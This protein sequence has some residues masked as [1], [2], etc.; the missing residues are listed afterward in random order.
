[1][2]NFKKDDFDSEFV[3]WVSTYG[4][5]TVQRIFALFNFSLDYREIKEILTQKDSIYYH[6]LRLPFINIL[7]NIIINQAESYREYLQ[8]IFIDYLLSGAANETNAPVQGESIRENLEE[9]RKQFMSLGDEFDIE[10]F[11]HNSFIAESQRA[12]IGLAKS[13]FRNI[14]QINEKDKLELMSLVD[15][16]EAR[17]RKLTQKFQYFRQQFKNIIVL[18]TEMLETLPNYNIDEKQISTYKE[19][20]DF[21]TKIG[22]VL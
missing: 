10:V 11:N 16:F 19:S 17:G 3:N 4:S 9:N 20:I 12:L 6:F 2:G 13:K 21:D 1:M 14:Q 22:E 15:S 5:V 8:K 18:N 7:N